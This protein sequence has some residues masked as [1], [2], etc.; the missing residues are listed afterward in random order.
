MGLSGYTLRVEVLN[1]PGGGSL[2]DFPPAR[3]WSDTEPAVGIYMEVPVETVFMQAVNGG[4]PVV[5]HV[6]AAAGVTSQ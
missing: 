5:L 2:A 4:G 6:F 3:T 1:A